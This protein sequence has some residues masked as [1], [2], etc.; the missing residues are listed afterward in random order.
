[1]EK[2]LL[3]LSLFASCTEEDI[4]DLLRSP[5]RRST[6]RKGCRLLSQGEACQSL[7]LL[8][9]GSVETKMFSEEGRELTID[10]LHSPVVLAPAFLF[11]SHNELPVDVI[12][13]TP[14]VIWRINRDGF[15]AFMASHPHVLR[16]FLQL[17]SDKG[18][19]LSRK[20]KSF[21]VEGLRT[22]VLDY[23]R[24]NGCISNVQEAANSLGV[25]RPSLSRLLS[26]MTDMGM[27]SRR[28]DGF[29]L[30]E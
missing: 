21:A 22:R 29:V 10:R 24:K 6:Y 3:S 8:T 25:V 16:A 14:C 19:F 18:H 15:L 2:E 12:A 27:V 17:V 13:L 11:A 7:L 4:Q 1:M 20:L 9:E 5:Y 30:K 23:L 26:E 28:E